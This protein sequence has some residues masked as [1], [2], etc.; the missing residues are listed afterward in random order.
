ME[1]LMYYLDA[2]A[3]QNDENHEGS[4]DIVHGVDLS[5]IEASAAQ[6][7]AGPD[8]ALLEELSALVGRHPILKA[9]KLQQSELRMI[10]CICHN[11]KTRGEQNYS[12][13]DLCSMLPDLGEGF[14]ER[15]NRV[16]K[17]LEREILSFS[18]AP[19]TDFHCDLHEFINASFRLNGLMWNLI[20]GKNPIRQAARDFTHALKSKDKALDAAMQMIQ[21]LF[22]HYPEL[23]SHCDKH[24]GIYYGKTMNQCLERVLRG[25]NAADSNSWQAF[26][27]KH[28]LDLFWQ[29]ALLL[30]LFFNR[31]LGKEPEIVT[32]ANLLA[33]NR[34]QYQS[35]VSQFGSANPLRKVDLLEEQPFRGL[36]NNLELSEKVMTE[37]WAPDEQDSISIKAAE[38][39]L[40]QSSYLSRIDPGQKLDQLILDSGTRE[41]LVSI[42]RRLKD[43]Q[44][45]GLAQWGLLGASLSADISAQKGCCVLLHG[46][47]GTGKTFIA[48]VLANELKRP[49]LQ[50]NAAN[51]RSCYYGNTEKRAHELFREM[52]VLALALDPVFLLNEGDQLI[53]QRNSGQARGADHAE[54]SIQSIFL[55]EM[56]S[57]PGTLIVTTNLQ[58]NLDEA[59][60]RRFHYKLEIKSPDCAARL[61][62][63]R[64]H[65]P[66]SIPGASDIPLEALANEFC[67]TG[68]QIRIVV[69][70]ACHTACLRGSGALLTLADLHKYALLEKGS[71][72]ESS[73]RKIGFSV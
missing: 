10:A 8:A 58:C 69:Q 55:E 65:L 6:R 27:R 51:I 42:I 44:A 20:L 2:L 52:R 45:E 60:S 63:W 62:L 72:F 29:K 4:F 35:Y 31:H 19:D 15:Y 32:I 50:V 61:A 71:S 59:M 68:G 66:A 11:A 57:F 16:T 36:R 26:T 12:F 43:P 18:Y 53:H 1:S 40:A 17:L 48:G 34:R 73:N 56:E 13:M 7:L 41:I 9:Y 22:M 5:G 14:S 30:I 3:P 37:L 21:E 54:N 33:Q 39:L 47:P 46:A 49:L 25:L 23:T 64:L 67:F 70:N 24:S 38:Q 28:N